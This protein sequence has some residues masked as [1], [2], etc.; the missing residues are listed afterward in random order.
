MNKSILK[1]KDRATAQWIRYVKTVAQVQAK[2]KHEHLV[3]QKWVRE[4]E[5]MAQ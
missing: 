1:A 2:C 4:Q 3:L 5:G